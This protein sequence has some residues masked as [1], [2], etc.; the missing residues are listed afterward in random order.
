MRDRQLGP[1]TIEEQ[2]GKH[3]YRFKLPSRAPLH[4][5]LHVNPLRL[6]STISL[7]H[8]VPLTTP[9]F[10]GDAIATSLTSLMCASSRYMD[11][12]ENIYYS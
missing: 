11:D 12:D 5:L 6:C 1:F 8:V 10:D 9:E 3:I 7:R 2:I 4:L